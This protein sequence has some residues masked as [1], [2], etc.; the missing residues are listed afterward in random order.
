MTKKIAVLISAD[1]LPDHPQSRNDCFE[2]EEEMGKI[3]PA[4]A[5]YD[6]QVDMVLWQTAADV[7]DQYDAMLPLFVWDYY[8]ENEAEFLRAM[9]VIDQK[10]KLH[11]GFEILKW[12]ANKT[13]L[14]TMAENGA[15]TIPTINL[16]KITPKIIDQAFE[17][18]NCDKIVIKPLVGGGAWRQ[19]LYEKGQ[20]FPDADQL[21]PQNA[22]VQPFLDSVLTE[23]ELSFLY[24]GGGFSHALVKRP[25]D[26][27]YRI[28]S[29]YGG[30]NEPYTPS[31]GERAEARAVLDVLDFT[32]LYARVDF[33]RGNDGRLC[34]IEL[35]MIEPYLYLPFAEGEGADNKGAQKLAEALLKRLN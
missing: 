10:T 22:M 20:A 1:L 27:D 25:K 30:Y 23:G 15:N 11:N 5:K 17:A 14:E 35:E 7:A 28:Q 33:L 34:L 12:N 21:P 3:I 18:L 2:L 26:G 29:M 13:Y 4:F 19:V 24:F 31:V 8:Q 9:A 6:M 16:E 32:P